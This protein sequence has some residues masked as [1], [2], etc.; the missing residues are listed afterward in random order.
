MSEKRA[1]RI[2]VADDGSPAAAAATHVALQIAL[3]EQ[4]MVHGLYV[5][6]IALTMDLYA[7][8]EAELGGAA[9][10]LPGESALSMFEERGSSVLHSLEEACRAAG[11]R[12]FVEMESGGV[13]EL[14]LRQAAEAR[15]LALGRRGNRHVSEAEHLGS[16]FK[17]I[18]H[19]TPCSLLVGGDVE[20]R[21]QRLL[22]AYDG[23]D[24]ARD[25]LAWAS[26]LQ[27]TL[28]AEADVVAVQEER[29]EEKAG[30]WLDAIRADLE[31]S[32]LRES[33]L[34]VRQGEPA[35]EIAVTAA[36]SEVDLIVV[37]H[38][39]HKGLLEWSTGSTIDRLL[40]DTTLPVLIAQ[41]AECETRS[42][43]VNP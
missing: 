33:H 19:A 42:P 26:A 23:S 15:I 30:K 40:R 29:D 27:K 9:E 24:R 10:R 7:D 38:Y 11:V 36:E 18:A 8:Y 20:P 3:G 39:R 1:E 34:L 28:S 12:V 17:A 5:V 6:D 41:S 13:P 14:V 43:A 31:E 16:N 4:L 32:E 2:L 21:V 22:L 35:S 37:G 25:A